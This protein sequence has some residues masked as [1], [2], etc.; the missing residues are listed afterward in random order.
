[1]WHCFISD[2][3]GSY[4]S[5]F[6]VFRRKNT[7]RAVVVVVVIVGG[8]SRRIL[9]VCGYGSYFRYL[10]WYY[11]SFVLTFLFVHNFKGE[12]APLTAYRYSSM[13]G[14]VNIRVDFL[15]MWSKYDNTISPRCWNNNWDWVDVFPFSRRCTGIGLFPWISSGQSIAYN[16]IFFERRKDMDMFQWGLVMKD[17]RMLWLYS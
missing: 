10:L 14:S 15:R 5:S 9:P 11:Q 13:N 3:S 6:L 8:G 2:L 1:M 17:M 12:R 7:D 16:L 4:G